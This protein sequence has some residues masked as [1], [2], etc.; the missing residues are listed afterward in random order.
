MELTIDKWSTDSD[1]GAIPAAWYLFAVSPRQAHQESIQSWFDRLLIGSFSSNLA[2]SGILVQFAISPKKHHSG[3]RSIEVLLL[4]VSSVMMFT[5]CPDTALVLRVE[6]MRAKS[7]LQTVIRT[8]LN[9][10]K[11]RAQESVD[12][13]IQDAFWCACI[14]SMGCT[15][16]PCEFGLTSISWAGVGFRR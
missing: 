10:I 12:L 8:K 15:C 9:Q 2:R 5:R 3:L 1:L 11:C 7:L 13:Y 14:S 6:I 4:E 16:C